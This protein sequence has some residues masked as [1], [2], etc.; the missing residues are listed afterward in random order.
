MIGLLAKKVGMTQRFDGDGHQVPV[1]VLEA[2]P[3]TVTALRSKE[4]HGYSA[5]QL[6]FDQTKEARVTK[7]RLGNFKKAG[8][9]AM[10]FMREI[11]TEDVEGLVPGVQVKVDNFEAGDLVDVE[12]V[13]IGK[14]FQGV[15]KRLHY[16]GGASKSHGSM[17]GRVPGGIGSKAGGV[18]CRK[19]VRKGKGLPG[20]MGVERVT[21]QNL[22]IVK[23]D[24]ENNLL[25]VEG[26]V[27]GVEGGYLVVR[28]A[29]KRVMVRKWKI[30]GAQTKSG[31]ET[32]AEDSAPQSSEKKS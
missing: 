22:K 11:R 24:K 27:P 2:G 31:S 23:I 9:G 3:C 19:K 29:L 30:E 5:V 28:S 16:K 14:G 1:T 25:L 17:F 4:K 8:A 18:G 26:A 13:S 12:G 20:H 6:A 21:V 7:A 32:P 15:V 10:R